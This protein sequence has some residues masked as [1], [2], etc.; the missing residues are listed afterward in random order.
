LLRAYRERALLSQEKLAERAG[1]SVR[2]IRQLEAGRVRRPHGQSM[3]LLGKALGLSDQERAALTGVEQAVALSQLPMDVAG[4]T[5]RAGSLAQ[6]DGLLPA[7][8]AAE[9]ATVVISAIAGTAGV[10]KTA[11]AVHWAHRVSARFSD[12]QLYVNLHGYGPGPPRSPLAALAQLLG[13]LGVA[14]DSVPVEVEQAAGMYRSLLAGRRMLVVLDN[15]RSAEQVRPLLP[16]SPTCLVLVTSRDGLAGLVATNGAH[17]L[18]LDVLTPAEAVNLLERLLGEERVAAEPQAAVELAEVCGFLPLALRIAAANLANLPRAPTQ[19]IAGYVAWLRHGDRLAELAVDGDPRAAVRP[20][21]EHSY[22][23]L[24]AEARRMFRLLG[25][26]PGPDISPDA[27]GALASGTPDEAAR[28][29]ER[30][31]DAHLVEVRAAG[32]FGLHDLLRRYAQERSQQEEGEPEREAATD[33]LLGWYLQAADSAARLLYPEKVRLPV[34]QPAAGLPAVGFEEQRE[35]LAWLDAE[36]G[37]L[38]AAVQDAAKHGQRPLAWLLAD[39]LRGWFWHSRHMVDWLAVANAAL[40]AA[41]GEGDPQAQAAAH[42]NLGMALQCMG[43]YAQAAEHYS[44]ALALARQAGWVEG[45]AASLGD[46]GQRCRELGQLEQAAGHLTQALA[47][48]REIGSRDGE[49]VALANLGMVTRE[50]GRLEQAASR[51]THALAL[52]REAGSRGGQAAALGTLG[53]VYRDLGQL[54]QAHE[55]LTEAL[56]L[57]RDLANRHSE[58]DVLNAVAAVHRD[59]GR[60]QQALELAQ[61]ALALAREI[62]NPRPQA[63]ARNILGTIQLH[64]GRH[65]QATEHHRQA[66]DLA[67]KT[68]ARYPQTEAL[69]GLAASYQH[70]GRS[71]QAVQCAAQALT[72]AREAGYRMLEGQA[73]TALAAAHLAHGDGDQ[74]VEHAR[75]ALEIQR[76]TCHRLGQAR[77][78]ATLAQAHWQ[79]ALVLF[80]EIGSPDAAQ[81][82]AF[83]DAS[84]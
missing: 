2:T 75:R 39:A 56:A 38:V 20:A 83:I 61:A 26:A 63:D 74:A 45:E 40:A 27:A 32:R 80:T 44:S 5:G 21:F 23:T 82:Q 79:Q 57:A 4:F 29:L 84:T 47:L 19:P 64:L 36:R 22:V 51:L 37:N 53:E 60:S 14:A 54:D 18:T 76:Q 9:P 72:L 49:A 69:L 66:L 77:T 34:P 15:A 3:R 52:Y 42:R 73:H 55:H 11:L 28:L 46:F 78:L 17:Q 13:G 7:D 10:G 59:A 81:I 62:G 12:G 71:H 24:A 31:A 6:L 58:A 68:N 67:L 1:L 25:L 8:A 16:G 41:E 65:Q 50:L 30:L 48:W 35:A 43:D 70:H 33:R